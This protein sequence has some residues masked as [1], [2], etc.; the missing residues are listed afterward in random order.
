MDIN[1]SI[2]HKVFRVWNKGVTPARYES[3]VT[4][5]ETIYEFNS[6]ESLKKTCEEFWGDKANWQFAIEVHAFEVTNKRIS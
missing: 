6:V 1:Q 3:F 2:S 4:R 5:Y